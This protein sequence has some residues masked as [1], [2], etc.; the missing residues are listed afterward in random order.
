M[1]HQL[2]AQ[3]IVGFASLVNELGGNPLRLLQ[4]AGLDPAQLERPDIYISHRAFIQLLENAADELICPDFGLR[5]GAV[6]WQGHRLRL[7]AA[8]AAAAPPR[9]LQPVSGRTHRVVGQ[10]RRRASRVRLLSQ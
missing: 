1:R 8:R 3:S 10:H 9:Q 7:D 2:R 5:L 4:A 6:P